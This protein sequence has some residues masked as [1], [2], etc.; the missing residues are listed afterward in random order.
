LV[1][2]SDGSGYVSAAASDDRRLRP[3]GRMRG[4]GRIPEHREEVAAGPGEHP[5]VPDE[6]GVPESPRREEGH[7]HR[8][9]EAAREQPE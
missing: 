5:Q 6:M 4:S 9:C 2:V 3:V 1:Y 7:T 8:V